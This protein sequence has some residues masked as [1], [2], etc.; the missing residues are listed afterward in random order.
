MAAV[1]S[2]AAAALCIGA[3]CPYAG[4]MK[5]ASLIRRV[6]GR[7]LAWRLGRALYME[8]RDEVG[9]A[10]ATNGEAETIRLVYETHRKMQPEAPFLAFDIGANLGEWSQALLDAAGADP[11]VR[12]EMFEP[13]PGA[14]GGLRGRF[15]GEAR[16]RVNGLA[17]SSRQGEA[18]MNIVGDTAGTNSLDGA[19]FGAGRS[20]TVKLTTIADHLAQIGADEVALVKIDAE[21]HDI[22]ILRSLGDLMA[23]RAFGL[24]Q[25]E[26][27]HRWLANRGSLEEV[28]DLA[29]GTDY[30][31]AR[32]VPAGPC[33]YDGWNAELDRYFEANYALVRSDVAA[34]AGMKRL[35]WNGANVAVPA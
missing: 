2:I 13:V 9:N 17:V 30:R 24:L 21:G 27:N 16:A 26:Y 22:E 34:A 23:R 10:I 31:V 20:L 7:N 11:N 8:A 6:V 33:L 29:A 4:A 14:L 15:A 28:F 25:F 12:V 3:R 35:R 19:R 1:K 5:A 32:I 18:E